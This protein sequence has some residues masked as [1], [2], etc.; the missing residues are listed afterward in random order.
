MKK[1]NLEKIKSSLIYG[2]IGC[3][4]YGLGDWLMIYVGPTHTI[5]LSF[6][7]KEISNIHHILYQ[8]H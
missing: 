8:W 7:T 4:C 2:I 1:I 3:L 6:L 5:N